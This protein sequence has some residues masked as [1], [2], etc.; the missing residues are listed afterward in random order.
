MSTDTGTDQRLSRSEILAAIDYEIAAIEKEQTSPGWTKWTFYAGFATLAW[1]AIAEVSKKDFAIADA[2]LVVILFSIFADLAEFIVK[3]LR[4]S[5]SKPSTINRFTLSSLELAGS[6][7]NLFGKALRIVFLLWVY[8]FLRGSLLGFQS[9]WFVGF[10]FILLFFSLFG[11]GLSYL[12]FPINPRH[13]PPVWA[14]VVLHVAYIVPLSIA[15]Y[16]ACHCLLNSLSVF[17][18]SDF[19]LGL[20]ATAFLW[21]MPIAL[22]HI[23]QNNPLLGTLKNVRRDLAFDRI[24]LDVALRQADIALDGM[25]AEDYLQSDVKSV[26]QCG[27]SASK[28]MR[29]LQDRIKQAHDLVQSLEQLLPTAISNDLPSVQMLKVVLEA[30]DLHRN[31]IKEALE[32]GNKLAKAYSKKKARIVRVVDKSEIVK[33]ESNISS[34]FEQ[35]KRQA[36]ELAQQETTFKERLA[37]LQGKCPL[38]LPETVS[39]KS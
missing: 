24:D 32:Q 39:K 12:G 35:L 15:F 11:F 29:D 38:L 1:I 6:R 10:Y 9:N 19:R 3:T 27:D 33:M 37:K 16:D 5:S 30:C 4:P 20:I 34:F 28:S 13:E 25:R 22:D 17:S 21:L 18:A 7:L 23:A 31:K 26:L 14:K 8:F 2:A 36:V